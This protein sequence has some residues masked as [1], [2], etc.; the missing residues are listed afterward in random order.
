MKHPFKLKNA[1]LLMALAAVYPLT[2]HS[3]AGVAQFAVGDVS[4]RRGATNL[5]VNKGQV[6]ESG[7][8]IVTG[9]SGQT[10]IRFSDGGFVSLTPNSQF[11][12]NRYADENDAG[13]DSFAVSFLRGGM[14]AIT[15]LIGKRKAE[16]YKVTTNTATIGIRGSAFSAKINPDGTMDVAGEQDSI[17]VCTNAGCVSLIVGEIVRV[18]SADRLPRRTA[19]RSNVPPLVARKDLFIPENPAEITPIALPSLLNGEIGGM[20]ALFSVGNGDVDYY[21]RGGEDPSDGVATFATG[22]MTSHIGSSNP[23]GGSSVLVQ[24]TGTDAGSFGHVGTATDP[25][26]IAWGYWGTGVF[27]AG[28][29]QESL[30]SVASPSDDQGVHYVVG[31]PTP[32]AQMPVTGAARFGLLGGTAPTAWDSEMEVLRVGTLVDA[33][34]NVDFQQGRVIG[35]VN[36]RFDVDGETVGV[37]IVDLALLNGSVFQS[38][39]CGNGYFSGFFTGNQASRAGLAYGRDNTSVGDV[40]GT[41]VLLNGLGGATGMASLFA[42]SDADL[43]DNS[44]RGGDDGST[45]TAFFSGNQLLEHDDGDS[46]FSPNL[47]AL[48]GSSSSSGS[49][50][51]VADADFVGWGYWGN[52]TYNLESLAT[53]L[54]HVVGRPTPQDQLPVS[55]TARYDLA[56]STAPTASL[57]GTTLTGQLLSAG[58]NVDFGSLR[59]NAYFNTTFTLVGGQVVPVL[60]SGMGFTNENAT[61]SGSDDFDSFYN[62]FFVGNQASRAAVIYGTY[63]SLVGEVRGAAAFQKGGSGDA[64]SDQSGI[65]AMFASGDNFIFDTAPRGDPFAYDGSASFVGTYL[66]YHDD[67]DGSYGGSS[68]LSTQSSPPGAGALGAVGDADFL[69][70][71]YWANGNASGNVGDGSLRDVHYLAGRPTP[72]GQMPV[73][74]TATYNLAGG[75]RPTATDGATTLIGTL[76]GASLS[77]DFSS[78]IVN[79]T[80]NTQ[81]TQANGSVVGVGITDQASISGSRFSSL[82]CGNGSV[83]GF[84][85]GNL[86][87]RAGIVYSKSATPV[88]LVRGAAGFVR[89]TSSGLSNQLD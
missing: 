5:P 27:S 78:G 44:P 65:V 16:N 2:A 18:D 61:F 62:G 1:A 70:W 67:N 8:N 26:L 28:G 79:A 86:A 54:H 39:G 60:V 24:K 59:V 11:N 21:L 75:T 88:G 50:G 12:I 48:A 56:G 72:A 51:N 55:G 82:G 22:L 25:G 64:H 19:L 17:E 66:Y 76:V 63:D 35:S 89:G 71:G 77:A 80:V 10:Q 4:V 53:G 45:G 74:G 31:R 84:F 49:L 81:F 34:L 47:L 13:K 29:M 83:N 6:I 52:A 43:F 73:T 15:G 30:I 37:D 38:V 85:T 69:G 46:F 36:T 9:A 57:D 58:L 20:S 3:A 23:Y 32:H 14:R 7:D 68:V 42:S 41:A 87:A 33:R 40:R